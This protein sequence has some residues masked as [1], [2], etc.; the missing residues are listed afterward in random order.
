MRALHDGM[1]GMAPYARRVTCAL[2]DREVLRWL[3]VYL[4]EELNAPR[5]TARSGM[6]LTGQTQAVRALSEHILRDPYLTSEPQARL[7]SFV[8]KNVK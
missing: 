3:F 7:I 6:K 5:L 2:G 1:R 4:H 8:F